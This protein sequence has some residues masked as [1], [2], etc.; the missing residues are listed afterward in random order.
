MA[1]PTMT[2]LCLWAWRR[3]A[4]G[5]LASKARQRR[6]ASPRLTLPFFVTFVIFAVQSF[7]G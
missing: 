1:A 5:R 6:Q 2:I 3:P 4:F 7:S